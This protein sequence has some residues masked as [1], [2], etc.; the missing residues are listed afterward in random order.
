MADLSEMGQVSPEPVTEAELRAEMKQ[1][2]HLAETG[3]WETCVEEVL[4]KPDVNRTTFLWQIEADPDSD[5]EDEFERDDS[6]WRCLPALWQ[7]LLNNRLADF[8]SRVQDSEALWQHRLETF[9]PDDIKTKNAE[10][11]FQDLL[12]GKGSSSVIF[13]SKTTGK[14]ASSDVYRRNLTNENGE[15]KVKL[16]PKLLGFKFSISSMTLQALTEP[17]SEKH[18]RLVSVTGQSRDI[19][20]VRLHLSYLS[21]HS[22]KILKDLPLPKK[23]GSGKDK[24][25]PGSVPTGDTD[26]V[27][28][29]DAKGEVESALALLGQD[30]VEGEVA[31]GDLAANFPGNDAVYAGDSFGDDKEDSETGSTK[32]QRERER[33]RY[34]YIYIYIIHTYTYIHCLTTTARLHNHTSF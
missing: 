2:E 24:D 33:E 29:Q 21:L 8:H 14:E 11:K 25:A 20:Q 12:D 28:E 17:P 15:L 1:C 7:T 26:E 13:V 16:S 19:Q 4:E 10:K 9:G 6:Q 18:V 27:C 31:D 30:D 22:S 5:V 32:T 23:S 34:I 3:E